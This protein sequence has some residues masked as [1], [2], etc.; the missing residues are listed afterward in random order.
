MEV[1]PQFILQNYILMS[2]AE[3]GVAAIPILAITTAFFT[4][5][6]TSLELY[7]SESGQWTDF[8]D[9]INHKRT[10]GDSLMEGKSLLTKLWTMVK[11]SPAFLLSLVFKV[12]SFT[13]ICTMLKGFSALYIFGG[14]WHSSRLL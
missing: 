3:R 4:I 1:S 6:K 7:A 14:S 9:F 11:I 13:I 12:G 5:A 10:Y 2:D 8:G